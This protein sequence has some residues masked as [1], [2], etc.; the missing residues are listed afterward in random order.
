MD[1]I[2]NVF[3]LR[4]FGLAAL[5]PLLQQVLIVAVSPGTEREH[6][7]VGELAA[8]G[9]D[10]HGYEPILLPSQAVDLLHDFIHHL[11]GEKKKK[12]NQRKINPLLGIY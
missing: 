12:E 3:F 1:F 7:F 8:V 2:F 5:D 9:V 11:L 10:E 6:S 4:V